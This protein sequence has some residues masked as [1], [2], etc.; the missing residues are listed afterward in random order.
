MEEAYLD[1]SA[2]TRVCAEAANKVMEMMTVKYGNPSSLHTKGLEA[3]QEVSAARAAVAG[4]LGAKPEEI[5]FTSGGTEANNIALFGAAAAR[6][7]AGSRIVS[8]AIEHPSVLHALEELQKQGFEVVT[9]KPDTN[10][11]VP[12][13]SIVQAVTPDTILVSMMLVNNEVGSVQPVEAAAKAIAKSKA[14]ALLH[15]DAVQAFGK[16]PVKPKKLGAD[17]VTVSGHKIHAPKGVG[18]LYISSNARI[19]PRVFGGGQERG[20]RPG[21][22]SA[23]LIAGFGAAV[24]ALPSLEEEYE[25]I[26]ALK[27]ACT[28]RLSQ[29]AGITFNSPANS[30]PYILN[31][32]VDGIRAETMLH[33]L[34]SR[35]VYVSSGS[36]CAKGK[37]SHV[38]LAMGLDKKRINSALRISFSR[39]N[40]IEDVEALVSALSDG[41]STIAKG[42]M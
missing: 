36:A 6:R 14:P 9:L 26:S 30:L 15:V 19:L 13:D 40:T 37:Q 28:E 17:L 18:A 27:Q 34:A 20:I 41:I 35:G 16:L 12:A 38:L 33:H 8:T 4:M 10:G 7:R 2:T 25:Q 11:V 29:L 31:I 1:N 23:P 3:E 5:I 22:E 32:S 21:T 39:Y 24:R 42:R